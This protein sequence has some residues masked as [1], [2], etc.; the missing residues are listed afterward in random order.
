MTFLPI[1]GERRSRTTQ[2]YTKA[3]QKPSMRGFK[4]GSGILFYLLAAINQTAYMTQLFISSVNLFDPAFTVAY[5]PLLFIVNC[6][7]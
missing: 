7:L 6:I 5:F 3:T 1:A 2:K 4:G